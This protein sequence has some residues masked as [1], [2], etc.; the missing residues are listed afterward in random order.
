MEPNN[1][2]P[3]VSES[4][5]GAEPDAK[6]AGAAKDNPSGGLTSDEARRLLAKFGPNAMPDTSMH[7]LRMAL[8]KFWAPVP[9]MLE[10]AIVLEL[11]VGKQVE[12]AIIAGLLVFNA[13]LGLFQ[14]SRAQATLAALKSR[15]ALN[16][17]VR[18]DGA[19]KIVLATEL[20]PGDL[21]KLSLGGVVAA[22]V[23]I[24]GGEVLLDQSML[25][26]ESVPIEAG[27]GVQTFA[28]ALVRRGEAVAEVTAT[29]VRTKFGRTAELV[30]TAHVVSSQ[31]KAVLRVVRNLA[32]FNGV[33]IGALVVYAY[34][35]NMPTAEII[36]LV[37]TA[38]LAS[39][40]V[41]LPA[42]FTLA[43]ALG[44][45]ALA[46]LGV[47]PTRLSAVDEA[48]TTEVLCAD[49]TG[50]LTQ[51]A[52][53]VATVHPMPG[54]DEAHVLALAALA[55]AD[56]GQ[57]PVDTAIR[58]AAS[59]KGV[60]DAPTLV[61]FES[62]D[63]AK[64]TSEASATD[65][66]GATLNIVK[67]A[68]AV[69]TG[70]AQPS[71]TATA[72][73][74]ELEG[75]GFRVLAVAAGPQTAMKLAGLIALSDPPRSDSAALVSELRALGVRTVMVT[76]DAPATAAIVA[77]AVGLDGAVCPPGPIPDSVHPEQFAVY[78]GV[79]P[80][81]KYNLVKAFQKGNHTVGMCGDGANDAPALRQA[82]IGIA[83][84]TATDVAKSAAGM[85]LTEPGLAGIVA[86]VKEGRITFQRIL[87]YT[88]NTIVK[89]I[90]TVLFLIVGL[91]M[92]GHAILTPLLMVIV[93]ITGDFLSMSLTTDNVRP[94]SLPNVWRIGSLTMAGVIMGVCLLA[95]CSGAL[96]IGKFG[97]N[98]DIDALR[99][100]AFVVLV[101]GNQAMLY[102]IRE[103][104]H[105]WGTPPSRWLAVSS[106]ADIVIASTL[107]VGGIAMTSL[108][109]LVVAGTLAA[110]A[111]FAF[112]LDLVKVP[113]FVRLG[114][115]ERPR[116]LTHAGMAKTEGTSMTEPRAGQPKASDS[117]PD[118]KAEPEAE[119]KA[120]TPSDLTPQIATRAYELFEQHGRHDGQAAQ[121]WAQ[122]EQEIRQAKPGK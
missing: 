114:I 116:P 89:K 61:K 22:D 43:A 27:A 120:K 52:L 53:T 65:S 82:Q 24:T 23:Q 42:T 6:S 72:T 76:G 75:Q 45:R 62:F 16:A 20:V 102:A 85:V 26:G 78:A 69:V 12:A 13:A 11:V 100:L 96:A 93:M 39:I 92:T 3:E 111:A 105:L 97:M 7:P 31:Q 54:F 15:L 60:S 71:P 70:L 91:I 40:P 44:A 30:R 113:V 63:P 19:W 8:E 5:P 109:L 108:P 18:R 74:N 41:A 35:L 55:S 90:V 37:L 67:G 122:A 47:L 86:A 66:S 14:E 9:W 104:R 58:A 98:L 87:T 115:A 81:D 59:G 107:A 29:G 17:S 84:S 57:D 117:K 94:S 28:G 110:A 83:V 2:Q 36:P 49:K 34:F 25:T 88:L 112:V 77:H 68:F 4:K 118:G 38:V 51:N 56:G 32:V 101:F 103:H 80:E 73:A 10:A 50:T 64:K 79:L 99:T 106:V 46:K 48:G 21:V 95:F 121:D 33:V 119:A 1:E